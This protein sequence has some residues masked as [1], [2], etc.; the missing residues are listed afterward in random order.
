MLGSANRAAS[1]GAG[2]THGSVEGRPAADLG[3][4]QGLVP[5]VAVALLSAPPQGPEHLYL[6]GQRSQK[7]LSTCDHRAVSV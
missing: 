3:S 5:A 2:S 4:E 1:A 6:L 7:L